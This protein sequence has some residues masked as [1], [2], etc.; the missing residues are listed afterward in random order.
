[1]KKLASL[2]KTNVYFHAF[3][4]NDSTDKMYKIMKESFGPKFNSTDKKVPLEFFD[5]MFSTMSKSI[6]DSKTL[7]DIEHH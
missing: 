6:E 5:T 3:K 1:M 7:I 2:S 4:I